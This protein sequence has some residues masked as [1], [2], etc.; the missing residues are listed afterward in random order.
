MISSV[1]IVST[2]ALQCVYWW[3]HG[4]LNEFNWR[5]GRVSVKYAMTQDT[6]VYWFLKHCDR[7]GVEI[8]L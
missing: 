3:S 5:K 6:F 1:Y 4:M 8:V 7:I 2:Y